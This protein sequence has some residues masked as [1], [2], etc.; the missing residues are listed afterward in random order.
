MTEAQL[1]TTGNSLREAFGLSLVKLAECYPFLVCDADTCGGTGVHHFRKAYPNRFF[2]FGIQEQNMFGAA[3]GLAASTGLP[4]FVTTFATFALRAYEIARLSIAYSDRNVK[5][6]CSHPGLDTG[7]DGTSAQ[8]LE[9]LACWR[10]MPNMV[11]L[12][13]CSPI[14]IEK[15]TEAILNYPHPIYMRTGR[16]NIEGDPHQYFLDFDFEIGKAQILYGDCF[17]TP[18][19]TIVACGNMVW[20]AL[21]AAHQLNEDGINIKVIN[22]ST[23]KP[24]TNLVE[25]VTGSDYIVTCED[26]S[27]IGGLGSAVNDILS[28]SSVVDTPVIRIGVNDK[29][30]Q[31]GEPSELAKHYGIDVETIVERV[32][33]LVG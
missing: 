14:E 10:A 24:M 7:P 3:A 30:G 6:V 15:A 13:P 25:L 19:V 11:V 8:C 12:S 4:V 31:S 17:R 5:I 33:E 32:K 16:S 21:E 20:R 28:F 23:L 9:D 1:V 27:I 18:D 2:Q 29:F 26:H 22:A